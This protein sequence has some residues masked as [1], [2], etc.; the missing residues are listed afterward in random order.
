MVNVRPIHRQALG[1]KTAVSKIDPFALHIK[2][3]NMKHILIIAFC[4]LVAG[5]CKKK[6]TNPTPKQHRIIVTW[7]D[8]INKERLEKCDGNGPSSVIILYKNNP[9]YFAASSDTLAYTEGDKCFFW[10]GGLFTSR[11]TTPPVISLIIDTTMVY[12]DTIRGPTRSIS[13][14]ELDFHI[15]K[16]KL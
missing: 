5:G 8:T 10:G 13:S 2:D 16:H 11:L 15:S 12:R 14:S 1:V 4:L 6:S 9:K 7:S 3:K